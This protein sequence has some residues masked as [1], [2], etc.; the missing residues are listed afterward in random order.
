[1]WQH[2]Y[3]NI[4]KRARIGQSWKEIKKSGE[5]TFVMNN[6][7]RAWTIQI[8]GKVP[9]TN[10]IKFPKSDS[11]SLDLSGQYIYLELSANKSKNFKFYIDVNTTN[12]FK[13]SFSLSNM[14]RKAAVRGHTSLVPFNFSNRKWMVVA[15]D[16]PSL[17]SKYGPPGFDESHYL[18]IRS[19]QVCAEMNVRNLFTSDNMY[20][21]ETIPKELAFPVRP[22][23][24]WEE[25]YGWKWLPATP[26]DDE[27]PSYS[28]R[29]NQNWRLTSHGRLVQKLSSVLNLLNLQMPKH[30]L[31]L[32]ET[33]INLHSPNFR[34][35]NPESHL[36]KTPRWTQW[37]LNHSPPKKI[38]K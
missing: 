14:H 33:T 15:I 18:S 26:T 11:K 8:R 22:S 12:K 2:P 27:R 38:L 19:V 10:Y 16:I 23:Q 3:V 30:Q 25:L 36:Q 29:S 17:I 31:L 37:L 20:D 35:R 5:A 7:V 34:F 4:C 24:S 1:M 28:S 6:S 13:L 32:M 21:P 9:S